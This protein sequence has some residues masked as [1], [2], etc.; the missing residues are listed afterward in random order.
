MNKDDVIKGINVNLKELNGKPRKIV[1]C[2]RKIKKGIKNDDFD[3]AAS[4]AQELK[5]IVEKQGG[6]VP[7]KQ[8]GGKGEN[9]VIIYSSEAAKNNHLY[10]LEMVKMVEVLRNG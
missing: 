7:A 3:S 4:G 10:V 6:I 8:I 9:D 2:L 1:I 5:V